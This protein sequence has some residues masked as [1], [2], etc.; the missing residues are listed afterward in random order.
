MSRPIVLLAHGSRDGRWRRP[1]EELLLQLERALPRRQIALAYLQ[2]CPPTL[3]DVM[4]QLAGASR[5]LVVPL[6]MSGGGH[7]LRDVPEAVAAAARRHQIE[8]ET[9]GAIAEEPE[10]MQGMLAALLRLGR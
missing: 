7:L 10:A 9:T 1:F 5:V 6:F 3:D 8:A 4:E 2:F